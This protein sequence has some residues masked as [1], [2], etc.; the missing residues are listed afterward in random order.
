MKT[1]DIKGVRRESI[2][3]QEV[4]ALRADEM[5]PCVLYGGKEPVHF[6]AE[7]SAFK[8]LVYTPE[9]H[10]VKVDID[11]QTFMATLQD[12][13]FH[14]VSD[15]IIHVDFLQVSDDKPV[16]MSIPVR[17][18]GASEGVKMG[19]KLVTKVRRLKMRALPKDL[20][21]EVSLDITN[22]KIGGNIRVRDMEMKGVTFL[23]SPTNVIVTVRMTRN[24]A[25]E[26]EPAKK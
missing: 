18:T 14:P 8:G 16:T 22:L 5:V 6:S 2:S 7:A 9:V 26:A 15:K 19:G 11:G 25:A 24:V 23:D 13:Q 12:V 17:L 10:M 1:Y 3:K 4:K 21:D 20:P